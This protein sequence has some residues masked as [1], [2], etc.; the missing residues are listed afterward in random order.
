MEE[1]YS[2]ETI[3][4]IYQLYGVTQ[5]L[6]FFVVEPLDVTRRWFI[7]FIQ[8]LIDIS[9]VFKKLIVA[10]ILEKVMFYETKRHVIMSTPSIYRILS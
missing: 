4:Y 7:I 8:S 5:K 6:I 9:T 1:T 10:H 3:V 2:V